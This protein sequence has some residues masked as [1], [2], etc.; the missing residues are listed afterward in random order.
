MIILCVSRAEIECSDHFEK[1][2][3]CKMK[4]GVNKT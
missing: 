2:I 1:K 4:A 3:Q